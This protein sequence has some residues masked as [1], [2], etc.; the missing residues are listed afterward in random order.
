MCKDYGGGVYF[1][2]FVYNFLWMYFNVVKSIRKKM[3]MF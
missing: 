3:I 1:D 2:G